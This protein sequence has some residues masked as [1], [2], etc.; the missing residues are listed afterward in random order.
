MEILEILDKNCGKLQ[1]F[2]DKE[3]YNDFIGKPIRIKNNNHSLYA[4]YKG[5]YIQRLV[6]CAADNERVLFLSDNKLDFRKGINIVK[7]ARN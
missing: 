3:D 4:F 7:V 1:L 5:E 2:F 6:M